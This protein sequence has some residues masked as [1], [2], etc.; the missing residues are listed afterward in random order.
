MESHR[1]ADSRPAT[2]QLSPQ[3]ESLHEHD[4]AKLLSTYELYEDMG[5]QTVTF[6]TASTAMVGKEITDLIIEE[7]L[8]KIVEK[9]L[10]G[11]MPGNVSD[12]LG[13]YLAIG[14]EMY[15]KAYDKD[16]EALIKSITDPDQEPV[17]I[18]MDSWGRSNL[19]QTKVPSVQ[20]ADNLS[21]TTGRQV[22][23][24]EAARREIRQ[25]TEKA[26][27]YLKEFD[28]T[29][30]PKPIPL[31]EKVEEIGTDEVEVRTKKERQIKEQREMEKKKFEE[32]R[33][34]KDQ[35]KLIQQAEKSNVGENQSIVTYA[36]DGSII[37]SNKK[38][39]LE[40]LNTVVLPTKIV[41]KNPEVEKNETDVNKNKVKEKKEKPTLPKLPR[42]NRQAL[43]E[44]MAKSFLHIAKYE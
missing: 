26:T 9:E 23:F 40:K 27:K 5:I 29:K 42:V 38:N 20:I 7:A 8:E 35:E 4:P 33:K 30:L 10:R 19:P 32:D 18:S 3:A 43:E 2:G 13:T 37:I 17:P 31:N 41:I 14:L 15:F 22:D 28:E 6:E 1:P 39:A 21:Y 11:R 44:M 25:A 36:Y 24:K 12:A 34:K 16:S